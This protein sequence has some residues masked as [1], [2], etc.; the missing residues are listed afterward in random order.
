MLSF[1]KLPTIV[2]LILAIFFSFQNEGCAPRIIEEFRSRPTITPS[3][4]W[5]FEEGC[6]YERCGGWPVDFLHGKGIRLRIESQAYVPPPVFLIVVEFILGK[7]MYIE[8]DPS[9]TQVELL[10]KRTVRAQGF[11]C[12][13]K[14]FGPKN[15]VKVP[16]IRSKIILTGEPGRNCLFFVFD[17]PAPKVEEEFKFMIWGATLNGRPLEIPEITFRP[18]LTRY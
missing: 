16:P 17:S 13:G 1:K 7:N 18:I 9:L 14:V 12:S 6:G 4:E 2:V 8:I 3:H 15:E 11:H 5:R 10:G